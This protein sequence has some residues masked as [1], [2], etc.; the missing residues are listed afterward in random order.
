MK[1]RFGVLMKLRRVLFPI[2]PYLFS[3]PRNSACLVRTVCSGTTRSTICQA[4]VESVKEEK[5]D[6]PK[7]SKEVLRNFGCNEEEI[8]KLFLLRPSLK[9]PVLPQLQFKLN[10][11]KGLGVTPSDLVRIV[12]CRPRIL[13]CRIN[14]RFNERFAYFMTLFESKEVLLKAIIR[15]PSLLTYDFQNMVKPVIAVYKGMGLSKKD[16]SAMLQLRPTIIPR[17]SF[18]DEKM[19]Y[20]RK[21]GVSQTSKM[22]KYVVTLIGVSRLETIRQ[23][24][25]NLERFGFSEEEVLELVGRSPLLLTLSMDK[26]QRNMTFAC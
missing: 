17:T 9:N 7:D 24:V 20:I 23:K 16:L 15:N 25:G 5:E 18:G 4:Q 3:S 14:H 8:S 2:S 26:V 19:E 1:P 13:S 12:N 10:L 22:Y 6:N 11:L 21:T